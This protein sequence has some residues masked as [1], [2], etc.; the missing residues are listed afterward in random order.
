M[1]LSH[2]TIRRK[3]IYSASLFGLFS[4]ITIS[5]SENFQTVYP[6]I[7]TLSCFYVGTILGHRLQRWLNIESTDDGPVVNKRS[8]CYD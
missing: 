6:P 7:N 3:Y 5:T 2:R 4:R 1:I 8:V